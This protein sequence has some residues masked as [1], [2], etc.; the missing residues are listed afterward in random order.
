MGHR[1][2]GRSAAGRRRPGVGDRLRRGGSP[3]VPAA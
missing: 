1:Q 2:A 3:P